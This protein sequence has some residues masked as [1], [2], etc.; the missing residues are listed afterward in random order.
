MKFVRTCLTVIIIDLLLLLLAAGALFYF[1]SGTPEG[2]PEAS[3]APVSPEAAERLERKV[4]A[5]LRELDEA[6]KAGRSR[7]V[8]LEVTEEELNSLI[9]RELPR[10]QEEAGF[11]FKV[12]SVWVYLRDG[13]VR[14]AA[15]LDIQGFKPGLS[16]G[17]DLAVE[18]GL[19]RVGLEDIDLGRV[20]LPGP[21]R[22]QINRFIEA[23][24]NFAEM[25]LPLRLE[26][27]V[28]GEGK[29]I[30]EGVTKGSG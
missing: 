24:L 12:E 2:Q 4:E 27:V 11:P 19:P 26:R 13:K 17:L 8:A 18:N 23:E 5:F 1:L 28:V 16:A 14:L 20:P 10:L 21:L 9:A 30:L 6:V 7:P 25:D 15:R 3:P 29:L 22:D